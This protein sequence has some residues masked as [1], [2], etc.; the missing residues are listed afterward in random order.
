MMVGIVADYKS[1]DSTNVADVKSGIICNP[2]HRDPPR[3]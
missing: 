3:S 1:N 2:Y